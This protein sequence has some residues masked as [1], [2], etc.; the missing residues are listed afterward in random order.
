MLIAFSTI[1]VAI[2]RYREDTLGGIISFG[3]A[4]VIGLSIAVV[5]SVVYVVVWE[6]Y[7]AVTDY[8]FIDDYIA[9]MTDAKALNGASDVEIA[10]AMSKAEEFK[11]QYSNPISRLPT[12]FLEVF[13]VGLLVSLFSATLLRN[14]RSAGDSNARIKESS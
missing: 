7:L 5:A 8:K 6:L 2:R 3:T 11:A 9:W 10:A 13:P 14:H 4:F 1:F 12:T